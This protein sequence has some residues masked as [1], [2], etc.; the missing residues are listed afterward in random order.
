MLTHGTLTVGIVGAG[1]VGRT[2]GRGLHAAGWRV[3]PV[4]TRRASTARKAVRA[5]GD[6]Q[7]HATLTRQLL[8]ADLVLV[9]TADA[10]IG[11]LARQLADLG[12]KEWRGRIV[13][14]SS[15]RLDSR[16]LSP[17]GEHG[18]ATGS[19]HPVQVFNKL[20]TTPLDG[21]FFEIE[22][23]PTALRAARRI[24][25]D[26]GCVPLAVPTT[27]KSAI[28]AARS[29]VTTFLGV[30]FETATR[31]LMAHGFTRRRATRVLEPLAQCSLENMVRLGPQ[32]FSYA[33]PR[34]SSARRIAR[35]TRALRRFPR[36]YR[37]AYAAL[38]GLRASLVLS[39]A[40]K[41][42]P[43]RGRT[44]ANQTSVRESKNLGG[45]KS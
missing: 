39:R 40:P 10:E 18:A 26:L 15:G 44:R 33:S 42:S 34:A 25:R 27:A 24:C 41:K 19:L 31:I 5:I 4:V 9:C 38:E 45:T 43:R 21:C 35:G 7:P 37:D 11:A 3:G 13:L 20:G 22:G 32:V 17:L 36:S 6:G 2:L 14:H 28:H 12:G 29:F 30:T 8:A 1:R 23:N 16:E